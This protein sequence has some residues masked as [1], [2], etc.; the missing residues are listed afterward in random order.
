M[1]SKMSPIDKLIHKH[2]PNFGSF[3]QKI[4]VI[5]VKDVG[6]SY[7][8]RLEI[9]YRVYLNGID[10]G[11]YKRTLVLDKRMTRVEAII[12]ARWIP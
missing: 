5:G 3:D 10:E 4:D 2:I 8:P 9:S 1:K 12:D 6:A 7:E 11:I